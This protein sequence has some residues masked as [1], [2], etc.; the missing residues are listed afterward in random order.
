MGCQMYVKCPKQGA[1]KQSRFLLVKPL[2]QDTEH[3]GSLSAKELKT[4]I[5]HYPP[6]KEICLQQA[7]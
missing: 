4:N 3:S 1:E 6:A 5:Y 2:S 7:T